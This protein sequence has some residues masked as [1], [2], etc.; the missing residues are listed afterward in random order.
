M[1]ARQGNGITEYLETKLVGMH[2]LGRLLVTQLAW[3]SR[4]LATA[5][6]ATS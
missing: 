2:Q 4:L 3:R 6:A 1:E 5:A